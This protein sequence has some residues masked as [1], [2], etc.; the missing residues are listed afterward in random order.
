ME[1]AVDVANTRN[2]PKYLE[3]KKINQQRK[4]SYLASWSGPEVNKL[5]NATQKFV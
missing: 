3:R 2:T 1:Y 4:G 5:C